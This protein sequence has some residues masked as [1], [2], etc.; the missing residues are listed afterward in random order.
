MKTIVF[1]PDVFIFSDTGMHIL[2]NSL[3]GK[4][5]DIKHNAFWDNLFNYLKSVRNLYRYSVSDEEWGEYSEQLE[6]ICREGFAALYGRDEPIPFSYAPVPKF[7]VDIPTIVIRHEKGEGGFILSFLRNVVFNLDAGSDVDSMQPLLKTMCHCPLIRIEINLDSPKAS[8]G[9]AAIMSYFAP[10]CPN[11]H[12]NL[13]ASSWSPEE[14]RTL[15]DEFP[16]CIIFL[17]G[18]AIELKDRIDNVALKVLIYS[19]KDYEL[20]TMF[21]KA[22][23]LPGYNGRNI[24]FLKSILFS[25]KEDLAG[26]SKKAVFIRQTLNSNYFGQLVI[27]EDGTV[28]AGNYGSLLGTVSTPLYEIIYK[29]LTA[30]DSLWMLTRDRSDCADCRFRYL[31]PSISDYEFALNDTRLCW[32]SEHE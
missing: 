20:A 3:N 4:I 2:Y 19:E 22:Q 18:T 15:K 12:L 27:F 1:N 5:K 8:S 16:N 32:L 10:I 21:K 17:T 7:D 23:I 28:R 9:C 6:E 31:C 30:T 25:H 13:T 26:V 24:D 11:I 29:E 14:V